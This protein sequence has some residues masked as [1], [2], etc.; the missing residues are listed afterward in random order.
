MNVDADLFKIN[1]RRIKPSRGRKLIAEPLL[2]ERIFQR[3]VVLMVEHALSGSMGLVLNKPLGFDLRHIVPSLGEMAETIP[4]FNGGPVGNDRLFYVHRLGH[5]ILN[6]VDLGNGL[7]IDGDFESVVA[8]L[9]S[10]NP[11]HENIC[12]FLGYSGWESGQLDA[13][14]E[15]GVWVVSPHKEVE[16]GACIAG[17]SYW[18]SAV[19]EMGPSYKLWLSYPKTPWLN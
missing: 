12:F 13:E 19:R 7:Y 3:S 8:Y 4:V 5:V 2:S 10:G 1:H 6:A 14:I 18:K 9:K 15:E 11:I 16:L 17:E